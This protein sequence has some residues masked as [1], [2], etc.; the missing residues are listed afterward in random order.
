[1]AAKK[2]LKLHVSDDNVITIEDASGG[3]TLQHKSPAGTALIKVGP[4]GI[5]IDNGM[6]AKIT[7]QGPQ[8]AVTAT[9]MVDIQ[10]GNLQVLP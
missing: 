1:M 2:E 5:T 9:A 3:I 8:V 10:S 4:D 7:L 6:G